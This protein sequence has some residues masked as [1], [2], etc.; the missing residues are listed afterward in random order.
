M[1]PEPQPA[2]TGECPY[3]PTA[4]AERANGQ[5]V[6]QVRLSADEPHPTCFFYRPDGE[7]QLSVQVYVGEPDVATGLVDR[8]APIDTSNPTE[9]PPGWSG[10]YEADETGAVY[11]VSKE[12]DAVIVTTNQQQSVKA[13]TVATDVIATLGL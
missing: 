11:A 2:T 3:L 4:E 10:G 13:R 8:A 9:Q 7:E 1:P 12:G 5:G 6:G